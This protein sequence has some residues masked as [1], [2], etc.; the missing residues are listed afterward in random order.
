MSGSDG[1]RRF[2]AKEDEAQKKKLMPPPLCQRETFYRHSSDEAR[3]LGKGDV[4]KNDTLC[5][6]EA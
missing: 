5:Y 6:T 4:M 3:H 2:D 1:Y